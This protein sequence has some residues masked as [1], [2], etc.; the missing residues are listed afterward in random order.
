MMRKSDG[1]VSFIVQQRTI[2]QSQESSHEGQIPAEVMTQVHS[3][4]GA[5]LVKRI[6]KALVEF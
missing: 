1:P 2:L 6:S 3:A 5:H 4:G